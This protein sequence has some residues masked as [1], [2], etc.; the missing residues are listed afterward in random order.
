[1]LEGGSFLVLLGIAMPLKYAAGLP[2]MVQVVGWIHGVL[3]VLFIAAV[4]HAA[5]LLRWPY[6]RVMGA[7]IASVVP[8]G[9]FVLDARLRKDLQLLD[10]ADSRVV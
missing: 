4:A 1:M 6:A 8:F 10:L 7:L 5:A 9:T 3:F 2:Q